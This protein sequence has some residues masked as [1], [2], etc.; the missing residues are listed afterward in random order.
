MKFSVVII[1]IFLLLISAVKS[2]DETSDKWSQDEIDTINRVCNRICWIHCTLTSRSPFPCENGVCNCKELSED[3][4]RFSHYD[5]YAEFYFPS[6]GD[7]D[8]ENVIITEG[9]AFPVSSCD[10]QFCRRSCYLKEKRFIEDVKC[11]TNNNC[12]CS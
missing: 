12:I 9:E 4:T 7:T 8:A 3:A 6:A 2:A 5:N 11:D 10:F 1:A